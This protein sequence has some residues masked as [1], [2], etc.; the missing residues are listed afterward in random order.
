MYKDTTMRAARE[1]TVIIFIHFLS[2]NTNATE[3]INAKLIKKNKNKN[4]K[5]NEKYKTVM[6]NKIH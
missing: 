1:V 5:R 2:Y 4:K 3:C 6:R